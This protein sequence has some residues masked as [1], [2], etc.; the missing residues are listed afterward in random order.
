M[1]TWIGQVEIGSRLNPQFDEPN[2]GQSVVVQQIRDA[3]ISYPAIYQGVMIR[4]QQVIL[5]LS[6]LMDM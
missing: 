2:E 3:V 5:N 1:S 4:R 6:A